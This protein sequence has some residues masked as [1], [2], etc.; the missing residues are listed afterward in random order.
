MRHDSIIFD[1]TQSHVIE[2]SVTQL[3]FLCDMTHSNK[4]V[5]C[6]IYVT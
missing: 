4:S 1:M 2:P 5:D 6:L 3:K